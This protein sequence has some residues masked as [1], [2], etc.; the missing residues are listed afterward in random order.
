MKKVFYIIFFIALSC[1]VF[2][3]DYIVYSTSIVKKGSP[4]KQIGMIEIKNFS[5]ESI[6]LKVIFPN[7]VVE[8]KYENLNASIHAVSFE[9]PVIQEAT[10]VKIQIFSNGKCIH[11]ETN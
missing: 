9:F 2:A 11:E 4:Q 5:M 8:K 10:E 3:V 6:D 7:Y 1:N